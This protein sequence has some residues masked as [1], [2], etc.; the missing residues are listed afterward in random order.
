MGLSE[1][2]TPDNDK[3]EKKSKG[4]KKTFL[5][6]KFKEGKKNEALG[7]QNSAEE[8]ARA[9]EQSGIALK[10]DK[11]YKDQEGHNQQLRKNFE[12][13]TK[14]LES[15]QLSTRIDIGNETFSLKIKSLQKN[16]KPEEAAKLSEGLKNNTVKLE[17]ISAVFNIEWRSNIKD[18]LLLQYTVPVVELLKGGGNIEENL[19]KLITKEFAGVD[20]YRKMV[21]KNEKKPGEARENPKFEQEKAEIKESLKQQG[22]TISELSGSKGELY[23]I[24][25]H[26]P[27]ENKQVYISST[28]AQSWYVAVIK[29]QQTEEWGQLQPQEIMSQIRETRE[30][31]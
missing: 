26:F 6:G 22:A 10:L 15:K 5:Y 24:I 25:A 18:T 4:N 21:E 1:I 16:S 23:S 11:V 2:F 9:T 28:D 20:H 13:I 31:E 14:L 3:E 30:T 8:K 7:E 12:K 19:R 29:N 17:E 27:T